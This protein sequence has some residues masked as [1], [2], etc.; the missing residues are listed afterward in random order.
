MRIEKYNL[1]STLQYEN[2]ALVYK[3]KQL[4]TNILTVI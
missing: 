1:L 2:M 4:E 3:D